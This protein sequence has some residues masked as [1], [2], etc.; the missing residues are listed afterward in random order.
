MLG[1]RRGIDLKAFTQQ[2]I[3]QQIKYI[4]RS[5]GPV[6]SLFFRKST[7]LF[8]VKMRKRNMTGLR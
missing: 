6:T 7:M 5:P 8:P 3:N 4:K 1:K 2:Y